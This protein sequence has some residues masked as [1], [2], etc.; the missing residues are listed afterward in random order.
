[1]ERGTGYKRAYEEA[2]KELAAGRPEV[3]AAASGL[4]Y[5]EEEDPAEGERR[6]VF[7][8]TYLGKELEVRYPEGTVFAG[9]EKAVVAVTIVVLHYL[10]RS[11]GPLDLA[12][13]IRFQGMQEASAYVS[14]FRAHA[15]TPLME[16]FGEDGEAFLRA[17]RELGAAAQGGGSGDNADP[18]VMW[19]VPFLPHLP[20]G[21]R[22]GLA[23]EGLPAECVILFPRRAGFI[24]HVEDLAVAG[25]LLSARM[26]E[27]VDGFGRDPAEE[28]PTAV[29][30]LRSDEEEGEGAD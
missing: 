8:V 27:A 7:H 22:L 25:E 17:V 6:G 13:P 11:V 15:E 14:A 16:R 4:V 12:D 24:Y 2:R 9:G 20:L 23:G 10:S 5:G 29:Y 21:I 3:M 28:L 19:E 26:V 30:G 18:E 1:M